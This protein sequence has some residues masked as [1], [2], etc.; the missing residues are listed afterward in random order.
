[1]R[2]VISLGAGVQSSTMALM[3]AHGEIEPMPD[4]AIFADTGWEPKAVYDWL[5]WLERQLPYPVVRVGNG[6]LR[7]EQIKARMRGKRDE[8]GGRWASIPYFTKSEDD[9]SVGIVRRQ[10]T[11]EYKIYPIEKYIKREILGL[12]YRQRAPKE[13]VVTQW[14]GI[15]VD[16]AQ[17]MKPSQ[18]KWMVVRH[19]LVMEHRMSR[20]DCKGWMQRQGY[21]EPP[22]SACIGCP[23]HDN[24]EWR[25]MMDNRPDEWQD[26]VE[27][28]HAIREAG[29]M[30]GKT[31]LHRQ[32]VPL[33]EVDL[34]TAEDEGQEDMFGNECDGMCGV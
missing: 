17:R 3:A 26:A 34:S 10:C 21:P 25:D 20:Q 30:R 9:V 15:S 7:E 22:R 14:R 18:H 31:Y 6:N 33:D 32:C 23:F 5:D 28:D 13:P 24:N 29:G 2:Q 16:E 12:A 11:S 4:V 1:M 19:P 27:F 8:E